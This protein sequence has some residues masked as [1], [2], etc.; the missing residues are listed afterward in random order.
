M[1][2]SGYEDLDAVELTGGKEKLINEKPRKRGYLCEHWCI[3]VRVILAVVGIGLILYFY[4]KPCEDEV[5]YEKQSVDLFLMV[6]GSDSVNHQQWE[7]GKQA[8]ERFVEVFAEDVDDL[9]VGIATFATHAHLTHSLDSNITSV[10]EAVVDLHQPHGLT[11]YVSIFELWDEEVR[12]NARNNSYVCGVMISDGEPT[13]RESETEPKADELK[14]LGYTIVGIIVQ[15]VQQGRALFNVS[16]CDGYTVDETDECV[17]FFEAQ[18]WDEL[19]A[20]TD[21]I[22]TNLVDMFGYAEHV[23]CVRAWSLFFLIL[24]LPL[25]CVLLAGCCVNKKQ[26]I[27]QRKKKDGPVEEAVI[28]PPA[29][30][31]KRLSPPGKP[32]KKYKWSIEAADHYLWSGAKPMPVHF[33]K[34][35]PPS[36]PR[37]ISK[38]VR[39]RSVQAWEDPDGYEYEVIEE[40]R[41][42]EKYVEDQVARRCGWCCCCC[43]EP[44]SNDNVIFE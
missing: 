31:P 1:R 43:C 29:P 20:D 27:M 38:G 9:Q 16:S 44:D 34:Q 5:T 28:P 25:V 32:K 39:R 33:G 19:V 2:N 24:L 4:L 6:D 37:D 23:T 13:V 11:N 26:T 41:T 17:F 36:A 14:D 40:E 8:A 18:D 10:L 15:N 22:A 42:L 12:R 30:S 35:A 3:M 21:Y 7:L